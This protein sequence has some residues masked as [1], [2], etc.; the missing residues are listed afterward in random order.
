[1]VFIFDSQDTS[2]LSL[3]EDRKLPIFTL[4]LGFKNAM[5]G[6][7]FRDI[8]SSLYCDRKFHLALYTYSGP[9]FF[10]VFT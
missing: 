4:L 5:I 8:C 7:Y 3:R 9:I 6:G 2:H 1:M 10:T